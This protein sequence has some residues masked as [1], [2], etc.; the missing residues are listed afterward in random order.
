MTCRRPGRVSSCFCALVSMLVG[1][2]ISRRHRRSLAMFTLMMT[3]LS[4][5]VRNPCRPEMTT[6]AC[7]DKRVSKHVDDAF[8]TSKRCR[9]E[10]AFACRVTNASLSRDASCI[11]RQLAASATS[12][13]YNASR[14]ACASHHFVSPFAPWCATPCHNVRCR[15]RRW[16]QHHCHGSSRAAAANSPHGPTPER[17]H[18]AFCHVWKRTSGCRNVS[19]LS[20]CDPWGN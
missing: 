8:V 5:H 14:A 1:R 15:G 20:R 13:H 10:M 6:N 9:P 17:H 18:N 19:R 4:R 7:R 12:N 2:E 16:N 3:R 11:S